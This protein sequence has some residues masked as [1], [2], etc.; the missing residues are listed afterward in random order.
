MKAT[1]EFNL[2]EDQ[3]EYDI[4][5]KASAMYNALWDVNSELRKVWKYEELNE[6]ESN[7]LGRIRDSFHAILQENNVNLNN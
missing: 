2:P 4:A 6:D 7:I 1:I 5:I 3:H